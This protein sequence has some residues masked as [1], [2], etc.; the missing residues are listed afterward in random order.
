MKYKIEMAPLVDY[1]VIVAK[2]RIQE[3]LLTHSHST[4]VGQICLSFFVK[5]RTYLLSQRKSQLYTRLH[6]NKCPKTSRPSPK[7]Y[8]RKVCYRN[9][10]NKNNKQKNKGCT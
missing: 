6:W 3:I 1:Y 8:T 2:E 4:R 5:E 7:S 10:I 9:G